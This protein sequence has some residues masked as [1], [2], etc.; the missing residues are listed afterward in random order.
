MRPRTRTPAAAFSRPLWV[1]PPPSDSPSGAR[2]VAS[3]LRSRCA[4]RRAIWIRVS[5]ISSARSGGNIAILAG[6]R[7]GVFRVA[8]VLGRTA[9][10]AA[11]AVLA[12]YA[13]LVGG[14]ASVDRATLMA[15]VYCSARA[16]DQRS[17]PVNTLAFVAS[18][19]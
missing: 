1:R 13:Y 8:G 12:A 4:A 11:I 18:C 14:G 16:I 15:I 9:M 17:S 10:L 6:R 5:P 3:G 7:I 19:L 2:D